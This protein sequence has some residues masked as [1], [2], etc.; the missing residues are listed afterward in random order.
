MREEDS[1]RIMSKASVTDAQVTLL[2][3]LIAAL[4]ESEDGDKWVGILVL[5]DTSCADE[6]KQWFEAYAG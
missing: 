6:G 2:C 1:T 5:G 3:R 4:D